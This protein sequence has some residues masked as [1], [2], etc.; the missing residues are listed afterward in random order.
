MSIQQ[1]IIQIL[2]DYSGQ[3]DI[4]SDSVFKDLNLDSLDQVEIS[5]E[6]H[7]RFGVDITES[8]MERIKTVKDLVVLI[9]SY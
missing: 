7:D 9:E 3:D 4:T 6:I 1:K 2:A 5:F 8:D